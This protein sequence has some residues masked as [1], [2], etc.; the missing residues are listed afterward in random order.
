ML[1]PAGRLLKLSSLTPNVIP[2]VASAPEIKLVKKS[3][4]YSQLFALVRF[5][6]EKSQ[7]GKGENES[8]T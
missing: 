6:R 2:P 3:R 7:R 8:R 1:R 5:Q 4:L